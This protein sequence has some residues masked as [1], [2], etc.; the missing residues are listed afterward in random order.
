MFTFRIQV[1]RAS[2]ALWARPRNCIIIQELIGSRD[3]RGEGKGIN[4]SSDKN[5]GGDSLFLR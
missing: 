1:T 2:G 3:E 4:K 5:V